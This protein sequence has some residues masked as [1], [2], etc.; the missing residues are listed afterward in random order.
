MALPK[1]KGKVPQSIGSWIQPRK[2][3]AKTVKTGAWPSMKSALKPP[4]QNVI[5]TNE[6]LF[7]PGDQPGQGPI[8][9][10]T[11]VDPWISP[12]PPSEPPQPPPPPA[13]S[14]Q[15]VLSGH[16][17][18]IPDYKS[19]IAGDPEYMAQM[20][21]IGA[22]LD[23]AQRQRIA[24]VQ[25]AITNFGGTPQGWQSGFGDVTGTTLAAARENPYSTLSQLLKA[26]QGGSASLAQ[27]LASRGVLTSG[28]LT[29][30]ERNLQSTYEANQYGGTQSLLDN[31]TG[32]ENAWT[33][34][35]STGEGQRGA[36]L[37]A[38]GERMRALYPATQVDDYTKT[39][40]P[41]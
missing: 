11:G 26:R 36:A 3:T 19:L 13:G 22:N 17:W 30:G 35:V 16:H 41:G 38:A 5:I 20:A 7:A 18:D 29:G 32:L 23:S 1:V 4:S 34:A 31:L 10:P 25:R 39:W 37:S 40:V 15:D 33:G 9:D 27:R 6:G 14:W 2:V 24:A 28:A 21:G 12:P 8:T